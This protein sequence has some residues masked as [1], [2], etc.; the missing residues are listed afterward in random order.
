M[1]YLLL[2]YLVI[3]LCFG[4]GLA[5]HL[6]LGLGHAWYLYVAGALLMLS[7]VLLGNVWQAF[8]ALKRGRP[9]QAKMLLG[10]T[11]APRLL[12]PSNR[13]YYYFAKGMLLLQDKQLPESEQC[14]TQAVSLGL[15][16]NND[17]ALA[18]LNLAHIAYV[19]KDRLKAQGALDAARRFEPSDLMIKEGLEK[20]GK[21]LGG[22]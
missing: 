21:V 1:V 5:L 3:F 10:Q 2:R 6:R 15:K 11:W 22:R 19:Q 17:N 8:S 18:Y 4:L 20:L 12:L 9:A 16:H 14:L 13:A 7:H